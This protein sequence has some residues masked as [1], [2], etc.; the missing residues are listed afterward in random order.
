MD[1][2]QFSF[3]VHIADS[4]GYMSVIRHCIA[5][6]IAYH[7][8]T[9]FIIILMAGQIVID[10]LECF[11]SVIIIRIDYSKWPVDLIDTA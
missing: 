2:H 4:P 1:R 7:C 8:V 9:V 5:Q 6:M 10:Q 11:L 3:L